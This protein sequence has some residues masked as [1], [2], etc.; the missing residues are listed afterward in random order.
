[1]LSLSGEHLRFTEGLWEANSFWLRGLI[2]SGEMFKTPLEI[3]VEK[4]RYLGLGKPCQVP[5][6]RHLV[7][8]LSDSQP[9]DAALLKFFCIFKEQIRQR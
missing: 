5:F 4:L 9:G 2:L 7:S 8:C 3:Q 1:M 6:Y